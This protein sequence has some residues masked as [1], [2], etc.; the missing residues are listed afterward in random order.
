MSAAQLRRWMATHG[1]TIA[2]LSQALDISQRQISYYR[3]GEWEIP[4]VVALA[5][6]SLG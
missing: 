6:R 5:L 2:S 3:S 1:H 4:K